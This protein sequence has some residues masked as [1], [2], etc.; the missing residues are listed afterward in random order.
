LRLQLDWCVEL[1]QCQMASKFVVVTL[2]SKSKL[3]DEA[4]QC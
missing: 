3:R 1:G 2:G 4:E